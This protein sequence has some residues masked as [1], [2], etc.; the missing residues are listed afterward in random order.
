MRIDDSFRPMIRVVLDEGAQLPVRAHKNDAGLDLFS[1]EHIILWG[2]MAHTFDTGVHIEIPR[3]CYGK[4][5]S[6]SGLN[7]NHGVVSCGGVIDSGYTGSICVKLYNLTGISY[8]VNV[9]DKIAQLIL[10]PYVLETGFEVVQEL[11][12]TE[13]G[14]NGFGSSGK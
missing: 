5:E 4:I 1:R 13:R 6:K 14:N 12:K 9:G 11:W 7:V 2:G 3:G 10:Q 8:E